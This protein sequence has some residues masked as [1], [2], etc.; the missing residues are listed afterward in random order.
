MMMIIFGEISFFLKGT[1]IYAY[2]LADGV[3]MKPTMT[4]LD[5]IG[6]AFEG[7]AERLGLENDDDVIA[8][9]KEIRKENWEKNK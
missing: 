9:V 4:A 7:E 2:L 6:K 8:M 5:N 1:E 3:M